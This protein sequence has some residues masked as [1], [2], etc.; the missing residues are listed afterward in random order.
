MEV[1]VGTSVLR[2]SISIGVASWPET[3]AASALDLM[4]T[5]DQALF[6]AKEGGRNRVVAAGGRPDPT[7]NVVPLAG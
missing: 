6:V 3:P 1:H 5:A 4:R 2:I 7:A